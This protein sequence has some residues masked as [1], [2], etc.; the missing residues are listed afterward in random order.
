MIEPET[1]VTCGMAV[2]G[3]FVTMG[4]VSSFLIRF[5]DKAGRK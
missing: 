5:V 4:L 3:V 1:G 2:G